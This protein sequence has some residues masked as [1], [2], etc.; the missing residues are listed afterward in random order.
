[1]KMRIALFISTIPCACR[2]E[3]ALVKALALW[4]ELAL[5]IVDWRWIRS[6]FTGPPDLHARP[7]FAGRA[8][9]RNIFTSVTLGGRALGGSMR[10]ARKTLSP[11]RMAAS[12]TSVLTTLFV[13]LGSGAKPNERT[14]FYWTRTTRP[15]RPARTCPSRRRPRSAASIK[16]P[17]TCWRARGPWCS[18]RRRR[19]PSGALPPYPTDC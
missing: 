15:R 7:V 13:M 11:S 10:A 4:S 6:W 19:Y 1:M 3:W 16:Y 9:T 17:R 5:Q 2:E 12:L 18:C 8:M 14:R